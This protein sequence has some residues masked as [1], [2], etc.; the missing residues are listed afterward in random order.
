M[1]YYW[2]YMGPPAVIADLLRSLR[3]RSLITATDITIHLTPLK[4]EAVIML[5]LTDNQ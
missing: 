2:C 3:P 5:C 1:L 4:H